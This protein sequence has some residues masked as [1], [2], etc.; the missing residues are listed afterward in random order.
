MSCSL[1]MNL[2][3]PN[4]SSGLETGNSRR[5]SLNLANML[6]GEAIHSGIHWIWS[7]VP[8]TC[9]SVHCLDGRA[10]SSSPNGNIFSLKYCWNGPIRLHS[11]RHWSFASTEGNWY[12]LYRVHPKKLWPFRPTLHRSSLYT[13][14]RL[15]RSWFTRWSPSN[16]S[17]VS[18]VK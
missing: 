17:F 5:S 1:V 3:P 2:F 15:L 11:N 14:L 9:E 13:G 10:L 6:D 12:E 8:G 16:S 4:H 7:S 18:S